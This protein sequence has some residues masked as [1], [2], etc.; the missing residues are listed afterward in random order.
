MKWAWLV[1]FLCGSFLF[2]DDSAWDS[3][4]AK[5]RRLEQDAG[6]NPNPE[7]TSFNFFG[8]FYY[9]KASLDGVAYAT[10]A[11]FEEVPGGG[12]GFNKFKTRSVHFNYD[13]GFQIGAGIGLPY[14]RWDIQGR[15]LRFHSVG[16]DL[17]HADQVIG[18]GNKAIIDAIGSIQSIISLDVSAT[19]AKAACHLKLD[20]VDAV[21]GRTLLWSRYFWFHPFVGIRSAW[22]KLDW[23]I[24]FTMP[25]VPD[26]TFNQAL[27]KLDV[28]NHYTAVGLIGGFDSKWNLYKGLGLFSHASASLLYGPSSEI[29]KQ[30]FE[31]MP[32]GTPQLIK[33]TLRARNA[34]HAVKGLFD[35][36]LGLK[37]EQKF[38]KTS[39]MIWG[40]YNF[41]Y[42]PNVSQK[43]IVQ[44][45]RTRD[46]S[47]LS[48][49]GIVVGAKA[50]F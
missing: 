26:V 40:G 18:F 13:P 8:E 48:F 22:I 10:T 47:D 24:S 14:D 37:W 20:V 43:T 21:L 19:K 7:R 25:I 49:Q 39:M 16:H 30:E 27:S 4:E 46:R 42:L 31:V 44:V 23:D 12:G 34:T 29:T 28:D 41:F 36:A 5:I 2:A 33:Q 3:I 38:Y 32:A 50:D 1:A 35:I 15:W 9:A 17:A 45:L 11:V 6:I